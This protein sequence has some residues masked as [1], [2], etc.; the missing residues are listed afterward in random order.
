MISKAFCAMEMC[1][2][3]YT[4]CQLV[5]ESR[6]RTIKQLNP[7]AG[8][9]GHRRLRCSRVRGE[10]PYNP[11]ILTASPS[12]DLG[13]SIRMGRTAFME[14]HGLAPFSG[15]KISHFSARKRLTDCFQY[16]MLLDKEKEDGV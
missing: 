1:N 4:R 7:M 6:T 13:Q 14:S 9:S 11:I 12:N 5:S 8:M 3:G 16:V 2:T 15:R 10:N